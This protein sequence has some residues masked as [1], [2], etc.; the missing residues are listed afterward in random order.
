MKNLLFF[1]Y[2]LP[3]IA[4]LLLFL[5]MITYWLSLYFPKNMFSFK[6]GKGLIIGSNILFAFTLGI[7]WFN[8]GYFPL[9]NLYESLIFLCWGVSTIHLIIEVQTKSRLLGAISSPILFFFS[10][11]L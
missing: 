4:C 7:R 9:S 1:D 5:A 11:V 6:L 10:R 2:Q 8:E 3:I